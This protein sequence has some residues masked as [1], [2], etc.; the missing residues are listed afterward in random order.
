[1]E[2]TRELARGDWNELLTGRLD[3]WRAGLWMFGER[4]ASG[5]GPG[6]YRAEFLSAKEA[7]MERGVRFFAEQQNVVFANAHSEPIEV[8]AELG[9]PGLLALAWAVLLA[10]RCSRSG[11][12]SG[13]A[14]RVDRSFAWS[15]LAAIGVLSSFHFPFRIAI[16]AGQILLFLAWLLAA[17]EDRS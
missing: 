17:G 7:L 5:V 2:K 16:V 1:V 4:P 11:P 12:A 10:A 9:V 3:G 14:G 15:S 13:A 8:G 6:A